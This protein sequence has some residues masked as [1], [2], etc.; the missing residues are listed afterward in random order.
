[1]EILKVSSSSCLDA[2]KPSDGDIVKH[3]VSQEEGGAV[4]Q[5]P[6]EGGSTIT[7]CIGHPGMDNNNSSDQATS[8]K[9]LNTIQS[10]S[11][12]RGVLPPSVTTTDMTTRTE[13]LGEDSQI[14]K[15][16]GLSATGS[17]SCEHPLQLDTV[18]MTAKDQDG[19]GV[20][21]TSDRPS[22]AA[23]DLSV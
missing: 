1:M 7:S 4:F 18:G 20:S 16:A 8:L 10:P 3:R 17:Q 5:A 15:S 13:T 2:V 21:N 22:P 11:E 6:K 19:L 23:A 12:G 14:S 9:K